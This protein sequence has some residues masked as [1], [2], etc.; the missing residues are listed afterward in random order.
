IPDLLPRSLHD[1]LP[2]SKA[3]RIVV[4]YAAGGTSDILAR[5][6]GPKLAEAWGLP[7]IVEN[8]P[9]ANGNVGADVVAKSAPDGYTL[10]LTDVGRSEE[11][12]SEL[13]SQ[14]NLV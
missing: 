13:Q 14:S 7:V 4:P 10:L 11:H 9:G 12:T 6:L 8:K 5:Q 1:A 2:I 3:I